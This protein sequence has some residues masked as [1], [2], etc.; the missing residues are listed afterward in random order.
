[1]NLDKPLNHFVAQFL[2]LSNEGVDLHKPLRSHPPP[3]LYFHDPKDF[4]VEG[5]E[6]EEP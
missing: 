4:L 6:L 2:H 5:G 1:M 3:H